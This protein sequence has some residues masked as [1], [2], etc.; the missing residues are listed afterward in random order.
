MTDR[1][2]KQWTE[3]QVGIHCPDGRETVPALTHERAPGLA[4]T[5]RPFGYFAV[6]HLAT[7]RRV[8]PAYER[9][10]N[11]MLHMA[12]LATCFDWSVADP[13]DIQKQVALVGH[14]PVPFDG[15]IQTDR[16]VT[17]PFSKREFLESVARPVPFPVWI[18]PEF[19][20]EGPEDD[21]ALKAE[22][23]LTKAVPA[24]SAAPPKPDSGSVR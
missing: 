18:R 22:D 24:R 19:P 5:F 10:A 14:E 3:T 7:G 9:C 4:I 15:Y 8:G 2:E 11:A 6:T 16:D 23:L 12:R 13:K 1:P 17:R 20:W 21:P